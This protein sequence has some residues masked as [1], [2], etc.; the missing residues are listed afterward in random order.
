MD[1]VVTSLMVFEGDA[2]VKEYVGG[3]ADWVA[4][5]GRLKGLQ[6]NE[7][8][9]ETGAKKR[10]SSQARKVCSEPGSGKAGTQ[11]KQ[12][13]RKDQQALKALPELI[14]QLETR[15]REFETQ[16]A[17]SDFYRQDQERIQQALKEV[18]DNQANLERA[19]QRWEELEG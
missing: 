3:Y 10:N 6:D 2:R 5:G 14:E 1:N 11:A 19:Y 13:S 4:G 16:I 8:L 7:L 15:Q 18:A 17:N 9:T 12:L